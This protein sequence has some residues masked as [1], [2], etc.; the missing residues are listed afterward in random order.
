ML[1]TSHGRSRPNTK[2]PLRH[3]PTGHGENFMPAAIKR[4]TASGPAR[5]ALTSTG[6]DTGCRRSNSNGQPKSPP[7]A[8][9]TSTGRFAD[10][11]AD[12][13]TDSPVE[14][15]PAEA[16]TTSFSTMTGA[17]ISKNSLRA[18]ATAKRST[19]GGDFRRSRHRD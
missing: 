4:T 5:S 16:G 2:L 14:F 12:Q 13:S 7:A 1:R 10:S 9:V 18:T 3:F 19:T 17:V 8:T 11:R 6:S 15:D